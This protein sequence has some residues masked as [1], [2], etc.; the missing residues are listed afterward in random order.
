MLLERGA[1]EKDI[2]FLNVVSCPEGGCHDTSSSHPGTIY[3][4]YQHHLLHHH[5]LCCAV[6]VGIS[7]IHESFPEVRI[8]TGEIDTALN[9][10]VSDR[11]GGCWVGQVL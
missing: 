1:S 9:Q 11:I 2:L 10:Q 7:A 4:H 5:L 8:V 6:I 3:L